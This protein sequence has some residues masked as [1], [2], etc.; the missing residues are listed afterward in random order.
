MVASNR[1]DSSK[2]LWPF[3][4]VDPFVPGPAIDFVSK[5]LKDPDFYDKTERV[6][7]KN[8]EHFSFRKSRE[9]MMRVLEET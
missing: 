6:A 9:R 3:T 5:L 4:T 7:F 1:Q 2:L 8:L